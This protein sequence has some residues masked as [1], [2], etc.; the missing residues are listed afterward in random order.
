MKSSYNS[1]SKKQNPDLKMGRRN[2][3]TF[4]QRR[5]TD[6]QQAHEKMFES[7]IIREMHIKT[8]MRYHLTPIRIA[9]VNQTK[10]K[11]SQEYGEKGT[12]VHCSQECELM[13]SL[14][15]KTVWSSLKKTKMDIPYNTA[16]ALLFVCI[17]DFLS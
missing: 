1:T 5:R 13:Q 8:T 9:T 7:Q 12:L 17:P 16:I 15:W 14:T 3:Q 4:F 10:N 11:C 6:D 2:E